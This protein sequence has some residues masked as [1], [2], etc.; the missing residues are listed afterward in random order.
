MTKETKKDLGVLIDPLTDFGFKLF[1][2]QESTKD[3][4]ISFLNSL[5]VDE[6]REIFDITLKNREVEGEKPKQRVV[7]FDIFCEEKNGRK[8]IVEMQ[9]VPKVNFVER[10][11]YYVCRG[12]DMQGRRKKNFDYEYAPVYGVFFVNFPLPQKAPKAVRRTYIVEEG[13][14]AP[15]TD[16]LKMFFIEL[17]SFTL[18]ESQCETKLD[19]WIYN[20]KNMVTLDSLRFK[21][22]LPV[23]QKLE[24]IMKVAALDPERQDEYEI[25]FKAYHDIIAENEPEKLAEEW[26]KVG[27]EIG[28]EVGLK[29]G[30]QE[31]EHK[32]K[33]TTAL[34][35]KADG[36]PADL[37]Q[38]YTGLSPE[39][40]EGL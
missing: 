8:F 28:R 39:T 3:A 7:R 17:P 26:K 34:K 21:Q 14:K 37:I 5:L 32:N 35:M 31:G 23:L 33:L 6:N 27:I 30:R 2:G 38:K 16:K 12:I 40:I 18:T 4:L 1:F 24:E 20:I 36:M 29:E 19:K 15:F 22:D 10:A 13:E 11:L 9:N 25:S